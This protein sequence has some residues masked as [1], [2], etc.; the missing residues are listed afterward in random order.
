MIM[1][2]TQEYLKAVDMVNSRIHGLKYKLGLK[3]G[4]NIQK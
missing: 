2:I 3:C 1:D 4:E